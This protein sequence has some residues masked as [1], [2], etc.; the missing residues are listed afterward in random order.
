[1]PLPYG[2]PDAVSNLQWQTIAEGKAKG[3]M[4]NPRLPRPLKLVNAPGPPARSLALAER[5]IELDQRCRGRCGGQR[6]SVII[7]GGRLAFIAVTIA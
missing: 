4:G 6:R 2:D 1:V 5:S 3:S 7:V